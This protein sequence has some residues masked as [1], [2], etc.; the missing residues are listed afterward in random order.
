MY[1]YLIFLEQVFERCPKSKVVA[2]I[3]TTMSFIVSKHFRL[4][5]IILF[6]NLKTTMMP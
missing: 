4:F 3:N 6:Q 2:D 5:N 1:G